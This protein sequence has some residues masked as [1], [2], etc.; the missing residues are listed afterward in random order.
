MA[1]SFQNRSKC[2]CCIPQDIGIKLF[3]LWPILAF[4]SIAYELSVTEEKFIMLTP[5]M[6]YCG[7]LL[8]FG[9]LVFFVPAMN[10][11]G[12]RIAYFWFWFNGFILLN[13]YS[14]Y[15]ANN[16]DWQNQHQWMCED[17]V[18]AAEGD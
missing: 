3:L 10:T 14:F 13:L 18:G 2:C 15:I 1:P 8:I 16:I 17:R 9:I 5:F 11:Y 6:A 12:W 4:V 7:L